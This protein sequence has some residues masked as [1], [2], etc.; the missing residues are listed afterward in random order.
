V[1]SA[2]FAR[3]VS[4]VDGRA[5]SPQES[6]LRVAMVLGGLPKPEVQWDIRDATGFVARVDLAYPQWRIAIE[7]DGVWHAG[8]DQL[9]PDRRRLNR[10]QA[11]GWTV[12]H[13]TST[14]LRND[15]DGLLNEIAGMIH[16]RSRTPR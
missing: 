13:V 15:L 10:L 7:Y 11:A 3:V 2:R 9:H 12:L 6:R 1:G 14:R 5:E 4:L 16:L 8:A